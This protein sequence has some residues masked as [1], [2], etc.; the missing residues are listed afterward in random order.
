[1]FEFVRN[2]VCISTIFQYYVNV[3]VNV[4]TIQN[5][6]SRGSVNSWHRIQNGHKQDK[7]QQNKLDNPETQSTVGTRYRTDT[8]K[9]KHNRTK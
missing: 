1:M 7:T 2:V 5:R 6:Q 9:T 4:R 3:R 8:N